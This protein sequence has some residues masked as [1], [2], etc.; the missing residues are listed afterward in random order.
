MDS[1]NLVLA[2]Q[3]IKKAVEEQK[4]NCLWIPRT[5]IATIDVPLT[6]IA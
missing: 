6:M 2:T 5:T 1:P 3:Q 4:N